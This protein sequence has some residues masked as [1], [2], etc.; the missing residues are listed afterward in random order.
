MGYSFESKKGITNTNDFHKIL[1][2][3]NRKPNNIWVS[4]GSEFYN[5]WNYFCGIII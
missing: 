5:R 3:C 1:D 4:K 2:E